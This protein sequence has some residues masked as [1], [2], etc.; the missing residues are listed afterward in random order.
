MRNCKAQG[1]VRIETW[2]G[3]ILGVKIYLLPQAQVPLLA[4]CI[5]CRAF[6]HIYVFGTEPKQPNYVLSLIKLC[7]RRAT[8]A[9]G[10]HSS[11]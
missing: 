8:H 5:S 10:G 3:E 6:L 11:Y 2:K 9:N 4:G 7:R 1:M